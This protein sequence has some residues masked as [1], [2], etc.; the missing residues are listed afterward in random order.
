MNKANRVFTLFLAFAILITGMPFGTLTAHASTNGHTQAQAVEWIRARKNERWAQNYDGSAYTVPQC[1]DLIV[2]YFNYLGVSPF[3]G[4]GNAYSYA[5]RSD[6]PSGWRYTSSPSAGDI[7]VW[8]AYKGIAREFGHVALVES[9]SG[10]NFNYVDVNGATG[11]GGSGTLSITNPSSFIHPDFSSPVPQ[12]SEMTS[13]CARVL[14]D[15]LYIIANAAS[16][17]L[18]KSIY[19]LDIEGVESPAKDGTNV[20]LWGPN[21]IK[22]FPFYDM[23]QITYSNGFY[24]IKQAGTNVALDV[25]NASRE[26]GANVQAYEN[27]STSA[28]KWAISKNG[29]GGYRVQA[30]CSGMSLDVAG[31][32]TVY[33]TN[34]QQW[35]N[36]DTA[37]QGWV[38]IK[39]DHS[40]GA[41]S[42]VTSATCTSAG[43]RKRVCSCGYT[44]TETIPATGHSYNDVVTAPTFAEQGYTTHTCAHCGDSYVDG[45]I[46]ALANYE[47]SDGAATITGVNGD[48]SGD[49]IIPSTLGGYPVTAIGTS[50]FAYCSNLTSVTIPNSVTSIG[51]DAFYRCSS[52]TSITIPN[53]VT[54]IGNFAFYY[55]SS[56]TSIT[57][58]D[59]VT[60]IGN[61]AFYYCSSLSSITIPDSVTSIGGDAFYRCSSLTSI[62]IPDSVTNIGNYA[63][64][65][66]TGLTNIVI[67]NSVTNIGR[68]AFEN[69]TGLASIT[70][71]ASVTYIGL[72]AFFG[73]TGLTSI[74]IPN[75][76]VSIENFTFYECTSLASITIPNSVT[77]IGL[78]AF[79][80]CTGL[81]SITIPYGV[82][83]IKKSAFSD[84]TNL[85]S[86]TIP[87]SVTSI[88]NRAFDCCRNLTDVYYGGSQSDWENV[89]IDEYND[90]LKNAVIHYNSMPTEHEHT[91]GKW[92]VRTAASCRVSGVKFRTCTLCGEEE[93][94]DIP[95]TGHYFLDG[96]CVD[97]GVDE[98]I[99]P[100]DINGD[101]TLDAVDLILTRM[102]LLKKEEETPCDFNNDGVSDIRDMVRMKKMLATF[103]P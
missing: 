96:F 5:D 85:T 22:E 63:F 23:W 6:L 8:K 54:S 48:I 91:F 38:F 77:Y 29:S 83:S 89:E 13:G 98:R 9:V 41:W 36:N 66:C 4:Y 25:N 81:T 103:L 27:N 86:I 32:G 100:F 35:V 75:S 16:P 11:K 20:S 69:C 60:S 65:N 102:A 79:F 97:C 15:G 95:A 84:C 61:Y 82:T 42:T 101:T 31:G 99:A 33:G 80:G 58:P 87:N 28:Q 43:S 10:G 57:I 71:P 34:I 94:A 21:N 45:Y 62:T 51:G 52:L 55:C 2:Y 40:Y 93:V 49:L 3:N 24:S 74:V 76:V 90:S 30:K 46:A 44:Q 92:E 39:H 14:D 19:F 47:I 67:P 12:G 56:L 73:C 50:A 68:G 37:A 53:S 17:D 26:V 88:S 18:E 78:Q 72:Q 1:V 7:A 59:S 70:I 64:E